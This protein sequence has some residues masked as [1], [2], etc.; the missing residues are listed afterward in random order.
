M[1]QICKGNKDVNVFKFY[2]FSFITFYITFILFI[3]LTQLLYQKDR[4][5]C[6]I[7]SIINLFYKQ[8]IFLDTTE[9]KSLN[10]G[11]N[12]IHTYMFNIWFLRFY[13]LNMYFF[14]VLL[15]MDFFDL[16]DL[17]N[18]HK[19][20]NKEITWTDEELSD[21]RININN[22]FMLYNKYSI[23]SQLLYSYY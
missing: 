18:L 17:N 21:F 9:S 4:V 22:I 2:N 10:S 6:I 16:K 14:N 13:F 1:L 11:I 5:K 3:V 20:Q 23:Y 19:R 7:L 8:S 15:M 12:Q